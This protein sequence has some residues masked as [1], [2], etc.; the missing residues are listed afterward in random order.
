MLGTDVNRRHAKSG[1]AP[2]HIDGENFLGV[3]GGR[4]RRHF[5]AREVARHIANGALILGQSELH[6]FPL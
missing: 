6:V 3:P 5:L 1:G 4:V 2:Q